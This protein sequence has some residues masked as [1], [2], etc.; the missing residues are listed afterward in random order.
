MRGV[1][2]RPAKTPENKTGAAQS[3]KTQ[4]KPKAKPSVSV[5]KGPIPRTRPVKGLT[6]K[7]PKDKGPHRGDLIAKRLQKKSPWYTSIQDPLHGA[8]CKIPDETGVETGTF[9][10]VQR[11]TIAVPAISGG[12]AGVKLTTP[13]INASVGHAGLTAPAG[14]YQV[15]SDDSTSAAIVWSNSYA[16]GGPGGLEFDGAADIR[17]VTNAH[18]IVSAAMYVQPEA[19]SL[20]NSG[21][22]CLFS[23]PFTSITDPNYNAYLNHYKSVVVPCNTNSA[24]VVRWYPFSR[25]DWSFK[26]F[27]RT[28]GYEDNKDDVTDA[29][30]PLWQFGFL[31]SGLQG[32]SIIRAT[33]VVNY[34]FIPRYNTLNVLDASPSPNDAMEVDLVENW[35]QQMPVAT[36]ISTRIA[37]SSPDSVS[38]KHED[39]DTG[40]GMLLDVIGELAP[41]ALALI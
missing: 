39:N 5:Q 32:D 41:I 14:N 27:I 40:F 18:R 31:A 12:V 15:T 11:V 20:Q 19:S 2:S 35:V 16:G 7:A 25:Q 34:E 28:D 23:A 30:F 37:S 21:E 13:Y 24:S 33:I 26:S 1:P 29:S 22:I 4:Q 38:P 17:A 10:L 3:N 36:P 6:Y 9:Q 8:D